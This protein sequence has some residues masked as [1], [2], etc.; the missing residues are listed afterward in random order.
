M[1]ELSF[2]LDRFASP[3]YLVLL[4]IPVLYGVL[5]IL[6]RTHFRAQPISGAAARTPMP[7]TWRTLW[8]ELR[9]WFK[10]IMLVLLVLTL[11]RPAG[12]KREITSKKDA[13]DIALVLDVSSSMRHQDLAPGKSRMAVVREFASA[14][15]NAREGDR[16]ALVTFARFAKVRAPL[17]FDRRAIDRLIARMTIVQMQVEDGTAIGVGLAA[18]VRR[19]KESEAKSKVIVLLTDGENNIG[20]VTPLDAAEYAAK[21][22]VRVH[23]IL[24]GT[25]R[26]FPGHAAEPE[27]MDLRRIAE[28]TGGQFFRVRSAQALAEVGGE[29]DAMERTEVDALRIHVEEERYRETLV[30]MITALLFMLFIDAFLVRLVP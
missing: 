14:L 20:E 22:G 9:P 5:L 16:I 11:A 15:V 13:V 4:A 3:G 18:A 1:R 8:I 25:G 28:L 2:L 6:R 12:G 19:L 7:H 17:T 10:I 23:T 27:S 21:H 26:N 24:A 29:I 30:P